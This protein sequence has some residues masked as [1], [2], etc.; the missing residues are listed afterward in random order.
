MI[1]ALTLILTCQ[2]LGESIVL[3]FDLPLPGPV[4]GMLLLFLWLLVR[5]GVS[6]PVAEAADGLLAHLPLLFIPAGVG[7]MVHWA[8]LRAHW[9]ALGAALLLGTL[10]ALVATA[11]AMQVTLWLVRRV[12]AV[13]GRS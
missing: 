10:I 11:L 5:G 7:V 9:Q 4:L 6:V 3:L 13:R 12:R 2:L 8:L 1:Q